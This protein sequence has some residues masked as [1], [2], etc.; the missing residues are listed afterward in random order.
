MKFTIRLAIH[1]TAVFAALVLLA[2]GLASL[3]HS[4]QLA[5][6]SNCGG[7]WD[8]NLLDVARGNTVNLTHST[9]NENAFLWSPDGKQLGFL[10]YVGPQQFIY[11]LEL[12]GGRPR[13]TTLEQDTWLNGLVEPSPVRGAWSRDHTRR[14]YEMANELYIM[15]KGVSRQITHNTFTD[16]SPSWSPDEQEIAY[17]SSRDGSLDIYI[18][19]SDGSN[20]R[21]LTHDPARDSS[22]AW[23][24][25]GSLIAFTS[26]RDRNAQ[27][28][29]M[30]T[31]GGGLRQL[32]T[33]PCWNDRALWRPSSE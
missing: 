15:D 4:P 20:I 22:P 24:P 29:V 5:Y 33:T 12:P 19:N 25:D 16:A 13:L 1:F 6:L 14:V 30:D 32:T 18:M 9:V 17:A 28:Y 31:D 8:I 3:P 11:V 7:L 26:L 27:I 10:Y 2:L 23:S 21:R